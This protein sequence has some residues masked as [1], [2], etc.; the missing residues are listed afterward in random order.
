MRQTLHILIGPAG[1][2]KS[3]IVSKIIE[4]LN[5]TRYFEICPDNIREELCGGNRADQSKNREVWRTAYQRLEFMIQCR[6][7]HFIFD[8]TMVNPKKRSELISIGRKHNMH[9]IA[10]AVEKPLDVILKQ[11]AGR[12]WSVPEHI[13]TNMFNSYVAPSIEEGFDEIKFYK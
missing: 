8:S 6:F 2:G 4:N 11:N 13:V 12:Q 3:T 10:H 9:I 5:T 1:A 7:D